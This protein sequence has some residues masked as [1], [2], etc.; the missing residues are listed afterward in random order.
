MLQNIKMIDIPKKG[1]KF[2]LAQH[3]KGLPTLENFKL[4]EF[5]IPELKTGG[6]LY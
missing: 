6:M 4:V 1:K 2:I 3:F 5:D